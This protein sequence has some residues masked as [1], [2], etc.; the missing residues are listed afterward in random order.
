MHLNARDCEHYYCSQVGGSYFQ[1]STAYQRGSG[2]FG[3]IRRFVSPL[4]IKVGAY[5]GKHALRAGKNV[6]TDVA[7]GKTFKES[8]RSRLGETSKQIKYDILQRLQ[9]GKGIKRKKKAKVCSDQ[10]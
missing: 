6:L 3:D 8:A 1:G 10:K 7:S 2:L 5:L 9:H 4:A